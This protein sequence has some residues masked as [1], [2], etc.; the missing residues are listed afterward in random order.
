[1]ITDALKYDAVSEERQVH[2]HI[3]NICVMHDENVCTDNASRH[4]GLPH[5]LPCPKPIKR[6]NRNLVRIQQLIATQ[7]SDLS[8]NICLTNV[9]TDASVHAA[10][11]TAC[12]LQ[13]TKRRCR[14]CSKEPSQVQPYHI[15]ARPT[16]CQGSRSC[17]QCR[18]YIRRSFDRDK[19]ADTSLSII[20]SNSGV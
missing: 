4:L 16:D 11:R 14:G 8:F 1:M 12:T 7:K 20:S 10:R 13:P 2:K 18:P 19:L 15:A 5:L 3:W 9:S 6:M 17:Y